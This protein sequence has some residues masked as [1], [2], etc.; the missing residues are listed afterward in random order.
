[1]LVDGFVLGAWKITRERDTATLRIEPFEPLSREDRDAVTE[2]GEQLVRFV[3][4]GAETFEVRF[5][6][7]R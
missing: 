2:E 5:A 7:E 1:V 6:E 3:G 4:E